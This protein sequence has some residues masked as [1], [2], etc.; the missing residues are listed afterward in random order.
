MRDYVR[1]NTKY[2]KRLITN[3]ALKKRRTLMFSVIF[4]LVAAIGVQL[5]TKAIGIQLTK[6]REANLAAASGASGTP[7]PPSNLIVTTM[8]VSSLRLQWQ[9]NSQNETGFRV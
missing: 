9:D 7:N 2:I 4:L 8:S 5:T 6:M 1:K 3:S